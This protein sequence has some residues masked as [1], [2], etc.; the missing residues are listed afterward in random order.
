[1]DKKANQK[2]LAIII[3]IVAALVLMFVVAL[4]VIAGLLIFFL[5]VRWEMPAKPTVSTQQTGVRPTQVPGAVPTEGTDDDSTE[6]VH[7]WTF[8]I[9]EPTCTEEGYMTLT[10][11]CGEIYTDSMA[12]A[13]G[14]DWNS[15]T[16]T[17]PKTCNR[18]GATEGAAP[19]H[20]WDNGRVTKEPTKTEEG[21]MLF[22][23]SICGTTNSQSIPVDN[24]GDV[25]AFNAAIVGSW[26]NPLCK[27][28]VTP[29]EEQFGPATGDVYSY[30]ARWSV[31][32]KEDGTFSSCVVESIFFYYADGTQYGCY[33]AGGLIDEGTYT[34]DGS[35]LVL[36]F[37]RSEDHPG[38]FVEL[39]TP[40]VVSYQAT[41]QD[42]IL[43]IDSNIHYRSQEDLPRKLIQ[44]LQ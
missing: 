9:K 6:H 4:I 29:D 7:T 36:T 27:G 14:H 2:K 42:D 3:G 31:S 8:A 23:C 16:C 34:F 22:T 24:S 39:A 19:D 20:S 17:A 15:A 38:H 21:E 1:M 32:F 18:C 37:I 28:P 12:P 44:E 41:I 33:G 35:T 5:K 10:C 13:T 43:I 25:S 40:K 26:V 11:D 30:C